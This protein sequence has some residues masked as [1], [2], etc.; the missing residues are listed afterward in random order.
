MNYKNY[1]N[2]NWFKSKSGKTFKAFNPYTEE[3][4]AEIQASNQ[5]D[6]NK[7][8]EAAVKAYKEWGHTTPGERRDFLR[9]LATR[10]LENAE[11]LAKT[12]SKEMGKPFKEALGEIDDLAEYLEYYS[13]L[14]RDQIGRIVAPVDKESMSLVKYEPYGVVGC[15]IPWNYPLSLMGWKLA[16]ALA[17]GNTVVMKPS[18]ITSLSILHWVDVVGDIMPPGVMNVI[19][20]YGIEAGEAIVKHPKVPVITFTGSIKTGKRIAKISAKNLK[21]VSLE[22]GGKDPVVI[23]DDADIEVAAKGTSWGGFVNAGQV[24]TSVERVYVFEKVAK[25]FTEALVEEA[26]KI[27][28]GNPM[29]EL[30]DV[31]PMASLSQFNNTINKVALAKKE[32]ARVLIGGQKPENFEKGYF[33]LP[34]VFDKITSNMD[35]VTEESFS[36][37]IPIQTIKSMDEAISLSNSTKYGLG[38]TIFTKDLEQAMKAADK[39][40]SGTVCINSPLMENI[41]APFGGM[42][43]SGIGREHGTEALE[44]FRQAKHIFIDY[45]H[46]KKDWWFN[47]KKH[48]E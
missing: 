13:E 15:I 14:A 27:K 44:E 6:V 47:N 25:K 29:D 43:Q 39:M 12:I 33:Y 17:A 5:A 32:G 48:H 45:N 24:C 46:E 20:G 4:I 23:C 16:P 19:T 38:C 37:V 11:P 28:L 21:K 40:K 3:V 26:K 1:I 36:P 34:T 2:N 30:T 41:A 10:S 35:I 31:G 7:A 9:R 8:V 18:E 42:K 22:L